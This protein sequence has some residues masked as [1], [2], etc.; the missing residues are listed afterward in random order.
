MEK[1][2]VNAMPMWRI[3]LCLR[4]RYGHISKHPHRVS[5]RLDKVHVGSLLDAENVETVEKGCR[6]IRQKTL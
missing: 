4:M 6:K 2:T 5:I 3:Y 1:K